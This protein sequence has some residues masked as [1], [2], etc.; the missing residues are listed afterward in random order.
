MKWQYQVRC[1]IP[2]TADGQGAFSRVLAQENMRIFSM[3]AV[4]YAEGAASGQ[5]GQKDSMLQ[6]VERRQSYERSDVAAL[7]LLPIT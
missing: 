4:V 6:L 3:L 1:H 2:A 7:A 5:S